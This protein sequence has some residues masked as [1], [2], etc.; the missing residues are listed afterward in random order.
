MLNDAKCGECGQSSRAACLQSKDR[1]A[2]LAQPFKAYIELD[3]E[4]PFFDALGEFRSHIA[5]CEE[6][7]STALGEVI[8]MQSLPF[9]PIFISTCHLG[10]DA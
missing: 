7:V 1:E 10:K 2:A 9:Q 6:H 4:R 3:K 5:K 8:L